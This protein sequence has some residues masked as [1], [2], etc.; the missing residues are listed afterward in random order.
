MSKKRPTQ[1]YHF[2]LRWTPK[3]TEDYES[4][5]FESEF[6]PIFERCMRNHF[7]KWVF[8]LERGEGSGRLH[9]QGYAHSKEKDRAKH[10]GSVL[11]DDGLPGV[12]ISPASQAGIASLKSYAMKAETRVAG[13]WADKSIYLGHDLI[14]DLLP[15]QKAVRD[16]ILQKPHPRRIYWFFDL[17]GG[18]GKSSFAKWLYY[19]HKV[20]TLTFGDAKDLLYVVQKF[21]N[22]P[23]YL[24]D[25]SRTK[26]GKSSMSDIYQALESVKNGYFIST[27][28]ESD[29]VCMQTPHVIVFSNHEPDL[30]CLSVDRFRIIDMN[31]LELGAN[32]AKKNNTIDPEPVFQRSA[33][34]SCPVLSLIKKVQGPPPSVFHNYRPKKKQ[35]LSKPKLTR[36]YGTHKIFSEA[37]DE[38]EAESSLEEQKDSE[39]QEKDI[40]TPEASVV[41]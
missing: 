35:K 8:Q 36:Q 6:Q 7:D 25:L 20:P 23:A 15:W 14:T 39:L 27:K 31:A 12:E 4:K 37:L 18:A 28:Y 5:Q 24:F 1:V 34:G 30:S 33:S 40:W 11:S 10:L 26:G 17:K 16:L 41:Q 3:N 19:H 2:S 38:E 32:G 13:P 29:I 22:K 21:E 9:M